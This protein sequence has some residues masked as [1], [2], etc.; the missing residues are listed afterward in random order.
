M[1]DLMP[2]TIRGA[3]VFD[4]AS[5]EEDQA[6]GVFP[7]NNNC[8]IVLASI[9]GVDYNF[10]RQDADL[11]WSYKPGPHLPTNLDNSGNIITD[12]RTAD[13]APYKYI[14][15]LSVCPRKLSIN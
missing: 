14:R 11:T 1:T 7:D 12:P 15:F 5:D 9:P 2:M 10:Y 4:G 6:A 3:V 8:L 13:I